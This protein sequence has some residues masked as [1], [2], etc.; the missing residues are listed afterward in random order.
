M[1][2]SFG[3]LLSLAGAAVIA[4]P[5]TGPAQEFFRELGTS[6]SSGGIGPVQPTEYSYRDASPSGLAR[7]D[8]EAAA[9]D[10]DLYNFALGP[11]RFRLAAG[12]GAEFNDNITL[13]D[14]NREAD[15]ILRPSL[16]L[17]AEWQLSE[18]NTLHLSLGASYAKY[19]SHSEFDTRG[20]LL[21]PT[22]ELAYT[23]GLGPVMFTVRDR[24]SYQEDP[25]EIAVLSNVARYRRFE[26]Q[27]GFQAD[28]AVNSSLNIN[29]GY[30]HFNLWALEDIFSNQTRS[31]DTVFFKPSYAITPTLKAGLATSFSYINFESDDRSDGFTLLIGPSIE[32]Q[33][34]EFTNA[35]FE[36]GFQQLS[37]SGGT[38]STE[39][40]D[41]VADDLNLSRGERK[42]L[43]DSSGD[44]EDSTSYYVRFEINNRPSEIFQHRL[45]GSKTS[46]IGFLSNFYDLYHI[47]YS[48]DYS[49]IKD[50]RVGPTVF[51]EY[52]TTSGD[53]GEKAHRWGAAIGARYT[54]TNSLTVGGSI[55]A[56][57]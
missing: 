51:Y 45:S 13:S 6:R 30:D 36:V 7:L 27:I 11:I 20:V 17:D 56:F 4:V 21:S 44:D 37:F 15:V 32:W 41:A 40:L 2:T 42:R 24:F 16:N 31:I 35:Y 14:D 3:S 49:G 39:L 46:E 34:S 23:F 10:E 29:G 12:L 8:P 47:E 28:W 43:A 57:S 54:V 52:Y 53:L 25:Y 50:I 33:L 19:L 9:K 1:R 38:N 26:N 5:I 48:A 22:S 55:I 18:M